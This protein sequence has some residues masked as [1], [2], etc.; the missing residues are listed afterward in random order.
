MVSIAYI[1][2]IKNYFF[3]NSFSICIKAF[4]F[5]EN[6]LLLLSV[7]K[8]FSLRMAGDMHK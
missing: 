4:L 6:S 7:F 2:S 8:H 1:N 3:Y 5:K